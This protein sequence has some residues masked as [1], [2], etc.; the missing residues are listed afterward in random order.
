MTTLAQGFE[1]MRRDRRKPLPP[2]HELGDEDGA[3]GLNPSSDEDCPASDELD[4]EI[5]R[6]G[7]LVSCF[8]A[9]M[10]AAAGS[11]QL[12]QAIGTPC[13]PKPGRIPE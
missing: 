12:Q 1:K 13:K 7:L 10:M 5:E 6:V 3:P 9:L 11:L 2:I 4:S 8:P